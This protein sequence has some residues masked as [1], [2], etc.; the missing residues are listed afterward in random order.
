M[1][2]LI[3]IVL[4]LGCAAKRGPPPSDQSPPSP[5]TASEALDF[6]GGEATE[7]M[8]EP[9]DSGHSR[10]REWEE[11]EPHGRE[12]RGSGSGTEVCLEK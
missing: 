7:P 6:R 2:I 5:K 12:T 4:S 11:S 10:V 8:P 3:P 1:R 9:D